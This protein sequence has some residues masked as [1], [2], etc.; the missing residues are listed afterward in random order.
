MNTK[1]AKIRISGDVQ[2]VLAI[3]AALNRVPCERMEGKEGCIEADFN[4]L[5]D[6]KA[7]LRSAFDILPKANPDGSS[8]SVRFYKERMR[9]RMASAVIVKEE[10]SGRKRNETSGPDCLEKL[11]QRARDLKNDADREIRRRLKSAPGNEMRLPGPDSDMAVRLDYSRYNGHTNTEEFSKVELSG[12]HIVLTTA[13]G[14][15][16]NLHDLPDL[17]ALYILDGMEAMEK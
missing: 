14:L 4:S 13:D 11:W 15:R 12:R 2:D 9:Y 16:V 6:A 8:A 1:K 3:A 5:N 17:A 7:A 10:K